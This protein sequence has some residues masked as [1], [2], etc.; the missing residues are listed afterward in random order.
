MK[1]LNIIAQSLSSPQIFD[2]IIIGG[3][4]SGLQAAEILTQK[5]NNLLILEAQSN[6]GGRISTISITDLPKSR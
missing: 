6:L 4:I 5:T 1:R 2:F 3:G